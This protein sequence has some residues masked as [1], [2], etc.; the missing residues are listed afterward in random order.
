M[1]KY[2]NLLLYVNHLCVRN[3]NNNN[4]NMAA[5]LGLVATI[6]SLA[7]FGYELVLVNL[8]R[9]HQ[10]KITNILD[11]KPSNLPILLKSLVA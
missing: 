9:Y 7:F 5:D 10:V 8:F 6:I 11:I 4:D 3:I 1:Q 2:C